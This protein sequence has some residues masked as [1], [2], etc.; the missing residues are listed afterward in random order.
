VR[1]AF[2]FV[3]IVMRDTDDRDDDGAPASRD[4]WAWVRIAAVVV[5]VLA[6]AAG[7]VIRL[8]TG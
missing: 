5:A 1:R 3:I 8:V 2:R 4:L 6:I 7:V